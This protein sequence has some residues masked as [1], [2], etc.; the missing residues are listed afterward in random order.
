[1]KSVELVRMIEWTNISTKVQFSLGFSIINSLRVFRYII[2]TFHL[3]FHVVYPIYYLCV[4]TVF[5]LNI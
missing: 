5:P 4:I 1:M 3:T 2:Y